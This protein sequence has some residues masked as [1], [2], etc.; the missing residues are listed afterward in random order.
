MSLA[1]HTSRVEPDIAVVHLSGAVTAWP[2]SEMGLPCLNELLHQNEKKV[3]VDLTGVEN[4]D[5]SGMQLMLD[6]FTAVREAGAE[7]RLAGATPRVA[8]LFQV[9]HLDAVLP[10]YPT[11]AAAAEAFTLRANAGH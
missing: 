8:R 2:D 5:S 10:F 1:A 4:M 6:C 11:V 9:T 3:I 7:L